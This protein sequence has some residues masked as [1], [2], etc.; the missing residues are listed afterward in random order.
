MTVPIDPKSRTC[1]LYLVALSAFAFAQPLMGLLG[2]V[3]GMLGTFVA[4]SSGGGAETASMV[5][6]GISE[7]LITTAAG[8]EIEFDAGFGATWQNVPDDLK[9]AV[10]LLAAHYYEYRQETGLG[11]GCMPFGVTSLIER[12]KAMRLGSGGA[13]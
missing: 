10:F 12:Y 13:R 7:A 2:T 4:I 9:Q 11:E 5:A 1:A 3:I 6:A 8:V